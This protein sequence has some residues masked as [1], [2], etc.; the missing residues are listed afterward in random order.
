M[1]HPR[2][3]DLS[4]APRKVRIP[5]TV[6]LWAIPV[7]DMR[8]IFSGRDYS[9]CTE[10]SSVESAIFNNCDSSITA[11]NNFPGYTCLYW[12]NNGA[13]FRCVRA[14]TLRLMLSINYSADDCDTSMQAQ[15]FGTTVNNQC[16]VKS[17]G[18]STMSS[19]SST[20]NTETIAYYSTTDCTGAVIKTETVSLPVS[21]CATP[22]STEEDYESTMCFVV[23]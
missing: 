8:C 14:R 12:S 17:G 16:Q 10:G 1:H 7:C 19:F 3:M 2:A 9:E 6:F 5:C 21:K 11:Y 15:A 4:Q 22:T 18:G 20:A 23:A 13:W